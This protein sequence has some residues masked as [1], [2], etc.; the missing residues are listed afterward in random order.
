MDRS[1]ATRAASIA[2]P[3]PDAGASIVKQRQHLQ[4]MILEHVAHRADFLVELAAAAHA[5][6]FRH[7]DLH[8][9]HV[10]GAPDG[11]EKRIGEPEVQ[12]VL[13]RLLSEEMIDAKNRGLTE[14]SVQRLVQRGRG[15]QVP[16]E[17]FFHD[18]PRCVAVAQPREAA[19]NR[20]EQARRDRQVEQRTFRRA[21]SRPQRREC[22]RILVVADDV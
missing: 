22:R 6:V 18:E 9:A 3:S 13:D 20:T 7:R 4:Q 2:E 21:Q 15:R 5:E 19:G 1:R 11:L 17:R 14:R 16:A 12:Q 8:A 10:T